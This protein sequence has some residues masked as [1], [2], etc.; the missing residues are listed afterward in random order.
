MAIDR[1]NP[2]EI[3]RETFRL[4]AQRRVPPTPANFERIYHE[5]AGT[6]PQEPYP[7]RKLKSLAASL[8]KDTTE[9]ARMARRFEQS[10]AKGNWEAFEAL[11]VELC[12]G[13]G[14]DK[15]VAW[16]PAIRDLFTEYQRVHHGLTAARKREA[17]Q[18]V[19]ESTSDPA[20]LHQ[21][22]GGLVRGWRHNASDEPAPD[23]EAPEVTGS[24]IR[25]PAAAGQPSAAAAPATEPA[26]VV[27]A[28]PPAEV[29]EAAPGA[30]PA[31][32]ENLSADSLA[33]VIAHLLDDGLSPLIVDVPDLVGELRELA[34]ELRQ[35]PDHLLEGNYQHKLEYVIQ[36]LEWVA[37]EQ[38]AVRSGLIGVLQLILKNIS[39]LVFDDRWLHGQLSVLTEAFS[40]PLDVR[41]L[42]EVER[43]LRDVIDKQGHLKEE[44]TEAQRR[45]KTM[46]AGFVDRLAEFSATTGQYHDAIGRCA[47]RVAKAEA[48]TELSD[49]VEEILQQTRVAQESAQRSHTEINSLKDQVEMAN[50]EIGRLQQ[51]LDQASELVRHDPLT[52]TLNR[53][54]M[55]DALE[56]EIARARRRE[57]P[58]CVGLLDVDNFKQLNDTYGHRAGDDA[59]KH[60]ADVI[61]ENVRPQDSVARYGGE[62]FL[63]LL[64]DTDT[65][66]AA[67]AL[68]RL[69]RAL[70]KRYFLADNKKLLITFSAGVTRIGDDESAQGAIERADR[71]MYLAKRA[72]KNRVMTA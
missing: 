20:T 55:D 54:G 40:R 37:E 25:S 45:L 24:A 5:V 56:R 36:R 23:E 19:L 22:I 66:D 2:T 8:P 52:G 18:H 59:L 51:E 64:P 30:M 57:T 68:T 63:V 46:L 6:A 47:E 70:T 33:E 53:K 4:L 58:L 38:L 48:I 50:V 12:A 49:V 16:G 21:R 7:A 65:D 43:R 17:L 35:T 67:A 15:T 14:D 72:G 32:P 27:T 42:D 13:D 31:M 39:Q 41:T 34:G 69:Q 3:A 44:L 9:R 60:L 10:V 29:A 62:E 1:N 71:A 61:R 28:R 26:P 11:I